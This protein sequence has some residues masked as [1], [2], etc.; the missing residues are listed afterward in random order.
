MQWVDTG[1]GMVIADI[2]PSKDNRKIYS[3]YVIDWDHFF[4]E[5]ISHEWLQ[6][7][8][9]S[10]TDKD[11]TQKYFALYIW[12]ANIIEVTLCNIIS[13]QDIR[14]QQVH[15]RLLLQGN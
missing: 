3:Q 8:K 4:H 10:R 5:K 2:F 15:E 6:F 9:E 14:N 13:L 12:G 11:D 7:Y 1:T